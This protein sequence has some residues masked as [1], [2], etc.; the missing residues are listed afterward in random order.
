MYKITQDGKGKHGSPYKITQ[1]SFDKARNLN[2]IIKP[3]TTP[4]KKIDVFNKDG[5]FLHSIGDKR[6]LKNDYPTYI[7]EKGKEY[8]DER[9]RLYK[10][11]HQKNRIVKNSAAYFADKILW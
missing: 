8:A 1:Y 6:Y 5:K 4:N 9:R 11:R 10:L 3:S 7:I 2:V